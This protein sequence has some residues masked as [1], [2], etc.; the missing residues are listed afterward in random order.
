MSFQHIVMIDDYWWRVVFNWDT[1][2]V[3]SSWSR[4]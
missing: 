4:A 2:K 1:G 3:T